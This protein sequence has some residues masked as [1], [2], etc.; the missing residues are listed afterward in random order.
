MLIR[1]VYVSRLEPSMDQPRI[2]A[3]IVAAAA[4]NKDN[5]ITGVIAFEGLRVCQILEGEDAKIDQLFAS[6]E[7]DARHSAVIELDRSEI[8]EK[9]FE[10]WGM[11]ERTMAD[12]VALAF[13]I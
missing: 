2:D 4:F 3:L 9:H 8:A 1:L 13:A 5:G 12:M 11:A 6:I 7:R 10:D